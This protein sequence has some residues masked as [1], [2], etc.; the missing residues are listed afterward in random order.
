MV[1]S[2][3][4]YDSELIKTV[5]KDDKYNY[6]TI[7]DNPHYA[8]IYGVDKK[9]VLS[10]DCKVVSASALQDCG[11]ESI[12]F[13]NVEFIG[14]YACQNDIRLKEIKMSEKV[15]IIDKNAFMFCALKEVTLP[16]SLKF[17]GADAFYGC[18]ELKVVKIPKTC[19]VGK[20]AFPK[21]CNVIYY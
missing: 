15:K 21:Q 5:E 20:N 4:F 9:M 12:D 18:E 19:K 16:K 13:A 10:P 7:N 8:I 14:A 2:C 1:D 11:I 3:F 6:I 17:L